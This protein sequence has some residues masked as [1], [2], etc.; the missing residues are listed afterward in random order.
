[1]SAPGFVPRLH[2]LSNVLRDR[3]VL[4]HLVGA[5]R[6]TTLSLGKCAAARRRTWEGEAGWKNSGSSVFLLRPI[7][8]GQ[9]VADGHLELGAS[10]PVPTTKGGRSMM[11]ATIPRVIP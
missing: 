7:Y 2:L 1:M 9:V 4:L 11:R 8:L 10:H 5:D 3:E 6:R